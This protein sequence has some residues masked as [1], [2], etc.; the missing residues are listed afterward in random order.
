MNKY[1]ARKV[2]IDGIT[3]ASKGEARRY[4]EL[5]FLEKAGVIRD[6]ELQPEF[7]LQDGFVDFS[8]A[9]QRAIKYR[10]DFKYVEGDTEIVEDFKGMLT[11]EFKLKKKMFLKRYPGFV[12]RIT[13]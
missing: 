3:F 12:F 7:V 2:V 4:A 5:K 11:A 10:A 1:R 6:L 9:K 13:T 8:G